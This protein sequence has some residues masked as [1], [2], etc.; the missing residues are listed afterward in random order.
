VTRATRA[1]SAAALV[2]AALAVRLLG[3]RDEPLSAAEAANAW[4]AWA[5]A[6]GAAASDLARCAP[7]SAFLASLQWLLF[8]MLGASD[9]LARVPVAV[10]GALLALLPL[11]AERR[12]GSA[13]A[14]SLS[15][16]LA[17]DPFLVETGRRA[18]AFPIAAFLVAAAGLGL[19]AG[20]PSRSAALAA[21]L[22]FV[23]GFSAWTLLP[24]VLLGS[25]VLGPGLWP[26]RDCRAAGCAAAVLGATALL[27]VPEFAGSVSSSLTTWLLAWQQDPI[28]SRI[29]AH[30]FQLVR[31]DSLTSVLAVVGLVVAFRASQLRALW[32]VAALSWGLVVPSAP[33]ASL[34]APAAA[35]LG[36][37]PAAA[38]GAAFLWSHRR[39]PVRGALRLRHA[40]V[41]CA[42]VLLCMHSLAGASRRLASRQA[43][44]LEGLVEDV[45]TISAQRAG[46]VRELPVILDPRSDVAVRW[47]LRRQPR[48]AASPFAG[49]VEDRRR[50]LLI[51]R[52]D[53]FEPAGYVGRS[54][55]VSTA[56]IML[57]VPDER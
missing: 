9:V 19:L 8:G 45:E 14:W 26:T 2:G 49:S 27:A 6:T 3:I 28:G 22:L 47:A 40:V 43:L 20:R 13:T 11:H 55:G 17:F 32:L 57:W 36:L 23:S 53:R 39:N 50:A 37:L 38:A 44:W 15:A 4:A 48:L 24:V 46:D 25:R 35:S 10:S 30:A 41:A 56:A 51:S 54:Y 52:S 7:D 16:L 42:L 18:D 5:H 34:A 33:A 21:G 31:E 1:A 29:V 12:L